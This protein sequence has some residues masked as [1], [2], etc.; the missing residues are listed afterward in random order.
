[1][2]VT[3]TKPAALHCQELFDK[4]TREWVDICYSTI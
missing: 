3:E 4:G 2:K 1:M